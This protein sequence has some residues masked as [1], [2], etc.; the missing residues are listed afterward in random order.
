MNFILV[1]EKNK[2][3]SSQIVNAASR[4]FYCFFRFKEIFLF[5]F[6]IGDHSRDTLSHLHHLAQ[7]VTHILYVHHQVITPIRIAV[8]HVTPAI[9]LVN[10]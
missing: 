1:K 6:F 2:R 7:K 5:I 8:P 4:I 3:E 10:D 9:T